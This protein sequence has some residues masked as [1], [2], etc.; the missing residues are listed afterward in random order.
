MRKRDL[1]TQIICTRAPT[2][3]NMHKEMYFYIQEVKHVPKVS[4]KPKICI[5]S[6]IHI[7]S[8]F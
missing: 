5:F 4:E 1:Y 7:E 6:N 3:Q 8:L 2:G